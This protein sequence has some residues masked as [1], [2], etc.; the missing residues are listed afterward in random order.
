MFEC[1]S[2]LWR[3]TLTTAFAVRFGHRRLISKAAAF[4]RLELLESRQLLSAEGVVPAG[5]TAAD[6]ALADG[7]GDNGS[8][9]NVDQ[10]GESDN[11][12]DLS[13]I[14]DKRVDNLTNENQIPGG[15]VFSPEMV[16]AQILPRILNGTPIG[17]DVFSAVG[18]TGDRRDPGGFGTGTLIAPQ[19]VLTAGHVSR[20]VGA[21]AGIFILDGVSY[22]TER[23]IRYPKFR[24]SKLGTDRGNDISLWELDTPV[25]GVTPSQISRVAP[26]VGEE[27][28]LVGYGEGGDAAGETGGF[29][30]KREGST[31]IDAVSCSLLS[32][33]FDHPTESNTGNGD[34]GGPAFVTRDGVTSIAGVTSGGEKAN[35]A[36][37]DRSFD[38][39]VDVFASWIDATISKFDHQASP[40]RQAAVS[41][42]NSD[43]TSAADSTSTK[44]T[45]VGVRSILPRIINGNPIPETTF[46]TVGAANS[47][48]GDCT[49]TLIAPQWILTAAHCSQG[50]GATDGTFVIGGTTYHSVKVVVH[51]KY[52]SSKLG[53]NSGNDIALWKLDQPVSGITPSPILRSKL[54]VGQTLTLVGYGLGGDANGETGQY[55]TKRVGT[56]PLDGLSA[57]LIRWNF[58]HPS[59]SNTAGGDSGGPAF[60]LV[61]GTYYVAGV[62]SGGVLANSALGDKSAD[63]RVSAY[64]KWINSTIAKG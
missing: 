5:N 63:T 29:G 56:T 33:N 41:V 10:Q 20:G 39:R 2:V 19:W 62:T 54:K 58:D 24:Y 59:E 34:S 49:A 3:R 43:G 51:P 48:L 4:Q 14:T 42:A 35:A 37:G 30:T 64:A 16:S 61:N 47:Q 44:T 28:T 46:P 9:D 50:L 18:I 57:K 26:Q 8:S 55:G 40:H 21:K 15:A 13:V 12:T 32:W 52:N 22:H 23:V 1:W 7:N 17:A 60:V 45:P 27:L 38:T 11:N 25:V 31:P 53:T 6:L 36:L